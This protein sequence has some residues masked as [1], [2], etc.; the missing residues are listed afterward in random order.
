[1]KRQDIMSEVYQKSS[2]KDMKRDFRRIV[3]EMEGRFQNLNGGL[4]K[5]VIL[6]GRS[7]IKRVE[8]EKFCVRL[9]EIRVKI[10]Y[11]KFQKNFDISTQ[12][13]NLLTETCFPLVFLCL[14]ESLVRRNLLEA[15]FS[16]KTLK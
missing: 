12:L 1:M 14:R 11:D 4:E 6:R 5:S 15:L 9:S 3:R 2:S 16:P 8:L 10:F 7:E 13:Q